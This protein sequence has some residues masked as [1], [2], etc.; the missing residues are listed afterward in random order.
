MRRLVERRELGQPASSKEVMV[1]GQ[2]NKDI[3]MILAGYMHCVHNLRA[4]VKIA[5]DLFL[6]E[7]ALRYSQAL[8]LA[9]KHV[10]LVEMVPKA[11]FDVLPVVMG[12][13]FHKYWWSK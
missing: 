2:R 11:A 10:G 9:R 6:P 1:L 5:A 3:V 12:Q 4:C 7:D 8:I 13:L